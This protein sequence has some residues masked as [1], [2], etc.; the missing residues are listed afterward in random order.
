MMKKHILMSWVFCSM[1][2]VVACGQEKAQSNQKNDTSTPVTKD[3]PNPQDSGL[4][5]ID[6]PKD[7]PIEYQSYRIRDTKLSKTKSIGNTQLYLKDGEYVIYDNRKGYTHREIIPNVISTPNGI[8]FYNENG[9]NFI[10]NLDYSDNPY[11]KMEL[12]NIEVGFPEQEYYHMI[13]NHNIQLIKEKSTHFFT[14]S[15]VYTSKHNFVAV[16]YSLIGATKEN[17]INKYEYT[18]LLYDNAGGKV[19][20]V[21]INHSIEQMIISDN[22]RYLCFTYGGGGNGDVTSPESAKFTIYDTQ[23]KTYILEIS[24]NQDDAYLG[25]IEEIAPNLFS[26]G[27]VA[28]PFNETFYGIDIFIDTEKRNKYTLLHNSKENYEK[29]EVEMSQYRYYNFFQTQLFTQQKF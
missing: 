21:K 2:Q 3:V 18:V 19:N 27:I 23:T 1:L 16:A 10:K 4:V 28:K 9:R 14:E 25:G 29:A 24:N 15:R 22:G 5:K 26:T 11:L 7:V 6:F 20:E 17:M 13:S 8:E 12:K